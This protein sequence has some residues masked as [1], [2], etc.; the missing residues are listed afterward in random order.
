MNATDDICAI[1]TG[2]TTSAIAIV[3]L[4]GYGITEKL[5]PF[6]QFKNSAL[7]FQNIKPRTLY[8]VSFIV[9]N[10]SVDQILFAFF[11]NPNSYTGEDM[12]ELY[13]HGSLYIQSEILKALQQS[14]I[15][16]AEPGEFT[17]RAY[18][19]GKMDL[20]QA[21]AVQDIID[22]RDSAS[23]KI[24]I[25]QLKGEISNE[26][27]ELRKQLVDLL[28]Y[29]EL[30]LDFSEEDVEF[31]SRDRIRLLLN[32]VIQKIQRLS[33]SYQYGDAIKKGILVAIVGETNVGKST[34]MNALLKEDKS[35]VS[36]IPGTTRDVVEDYFTYEGFT[37]RFADT[38]GIRSSTDEI[39]K[40][41]IE[42]AIEKAK[43]ANIV[44][45][46]VNAESTIDEIKQQLNYW[47]STINNEN[48]AVFLLLN[49]ADKLTEQD[50]QRKLNELKEFYEHTLAISA[51]FNI[52]LHELLSRMVA[53]VRSLNITG[54]EYAITSARQW[55][56]L[57]QALQY[58]K[59]AIESLD[60]GK[61]SDLLAE[62]LRMVNV[63]LSEVTGEIPHTEVLNEI[64]SRFCIGK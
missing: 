37:F 55:H 57:Q 42:R 31:A 15:R 43:H 12:I 32:E 50:L 40:I 33:L 63:Y 56:L 10:Q 59:M 46:L 64:F 20:T 28:V 30:E 3:R 2:L 4:S 14:G 61:T 8:N 22:S 24:A 47:K 48:K 21:E 1:A 27:K 54:S 7:S 17:L 51:K 5:L 19:N 62:D 23:H 38:A 36:S 16:M 11:K 35:I 25:S 45:I 52:H 13:C 29:V 34:L 44:L 39:E 60:E 9:D 53:Y 6:I 58:A 41:G 49:K 26:I 18:L